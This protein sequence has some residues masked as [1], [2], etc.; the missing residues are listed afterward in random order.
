MKHR[1]YL[2]DFDLFVCIV[3]TLVACYLT[4]HFSLI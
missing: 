2:L 3:I 1:K 4:L